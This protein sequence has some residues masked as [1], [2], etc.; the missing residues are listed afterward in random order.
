MIGGR[1]G[2]SLTVR[3]YICVNESLVSTRVTRHYLHQLMVLYQHHLNP[4]AIYGC[5]E[6]LPRH[7]TL[8]SEEL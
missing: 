4:T 1:V 8:S 7:V 2:G 6:R 5:F 3:Q